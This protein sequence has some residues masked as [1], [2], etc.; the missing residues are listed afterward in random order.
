VTNQYGGTSQEALINNKWERAGYTVLVT[1]LADIKWI[2]GDCF[3]D[4]FRSLKACM[5]SDDAVNNTT[6]VVEF[7][8][9]SWTNPNSVTTKLKNLKDVTT[10]NKDNFN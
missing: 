10:R 2:E 8:C 3:Y 9:E 6:D 5:A 7:K 4:T 1:N